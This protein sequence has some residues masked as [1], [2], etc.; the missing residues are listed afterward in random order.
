MILQANY[1]SF[2]CAGRESSSSGITIIGTGSSSTLLD[3]LRRS[4]TKVLKRWSL[5]GSSSSS[6]N[7]TGN[8]TI[9]YSST[10]IR[11]SYASILF[12]SNWASSISSLS[13]NS[14]RRV[15]FGPLLSYFYLQGEPKKTVLFGENFQKFFQKSHENTPY[16]WFLK[17]NWKFFTKKRK[18]TVFWLTL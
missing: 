4:L 8:K 16:R 7:S 15:S 11:L 6:S 2:S 3:G 13:V 12:C 10:G 18:S 5:F 17:K 1:A 14:K 9:S